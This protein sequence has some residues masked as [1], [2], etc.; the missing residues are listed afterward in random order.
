[1]PQWGGYK[2]DSETTVLKDGTSI[3]KLVRKDL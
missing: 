3:T 1:M 2:L